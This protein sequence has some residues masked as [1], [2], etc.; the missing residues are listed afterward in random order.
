MKI[1]VDTDSNLPAKVVPDSLLENI[2]HFLLLVVLPGLDFLV[3]S[4][5][6]PEWQSGK[7]NDY[8]ALLLSNR[9]AYVFFPLLIYAI[10]AFVLLITNPQKYAPKFVI[11]L[12]IYTGVLLALQYTILATITL[13]IS[14]AA[15]VGLVVVGWL[16]PKIRSKWVRLLVIVL[17]LAA[18][19]V[20]MDI[21]ITE[22][23]DI[24]FNMIMVMIVFL[25]F[26]APCL[27]FF[28]ALTYAIRLFKVYDRPIVFK[29]NRAMGVGAWLAGYTAAWIISI[30]QMFKI[31][32]TLPK[33]N[34]DCYI[35]TTAA[36]GH[37]GF[38]GSH[39]VHLPNGTLWVNRQLQT[40]KYAELVL[41]ALAPRFH[42]PLRV[43]Y[44][45][46][47][48]RLSRCLVHPI[49]AD[50]AYLSFKPAELLFR[51]V[52][53]WLIPDLDVYINQMYRAG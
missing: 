31:Y 14:L 24:I 44:D 11:R 21:P 29:A 45:V 46:I 36:Q 47:G 37:P 39:L 22:S 33:T 35:A 27:C 32:N 42:R 6:A 38:V 40:L 52:L 5:L 41:Q 13:P 3:S 50:L 4:F 16:I 12:G 51:F 8:V 17:L 43:L 7:F 18:G 28:V 23:F 34:P 20:L 2:L 49:L 25:G 26:G 53:R 19:I 10:V 15:G 48:P 9:V 30:N 1:S